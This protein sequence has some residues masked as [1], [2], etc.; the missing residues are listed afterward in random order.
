MFGLVQLAI[1]RKLRLKKMLL[2]SI[3]YVIYRTYQRYSWG[4]RTDYSISVTYKIQVAT[5]LGS[6][7]PSEKS[8]VNFEI[9][10]VIMT[11]NLFG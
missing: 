11:K 5:F 8:A 1:K 10:S 3:D 6:Y 7:R 9:E 4:L 2:P